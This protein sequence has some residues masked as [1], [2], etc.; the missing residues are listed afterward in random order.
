MK[1]QLSLLIMYL[2]LLVI[3]LS[4]YAQVS[5][6]KGIKWTTGLT[7]EQVKQKAKSENKYVFLDCYTTWCGPCRMMDMQVYSNDSVGDYYNDRFIS[8]KVQMDKTN[9][10]DEEVKKWYATAEAMITD[11]KIEGYPSFVFISP[12]GVIV[13][14]DIGYK[15]ADSLVAIARLAT[16]PGRV[17]DDGY[18][19]Y[20]RLMEDYNKG[21]KN[22][23][24]YPFMINMAMRLNDQQMAVKLLKELTDSVSL[25]PPKERYKKEIIQLWALFTL[26]TDRP[27][28]SFFYNDGKLIDE[29][30]DQKGFSASMVDKSIQ[31]TIVTP[32]LQE[33]AKGSGVV[34]SGMYMSGPELKLDS[35]EADW[36]QLEKM[37]SEK[38]N[39]DVTKRNLLSARV[40]WYKRH[41][42]YPA[43]IKYALDKLNNYPPDLKSPVPVININNDAFT[44]FIYSTDQKLLL[45]YIKWMGKMVKAY[46]DRYTS[47]DTYANLL[48]KAGKRKEAIKWQEKAVKMAPGDPGIAKA[49]EDMRAGKP[50]YLDQ[51]VVW[52]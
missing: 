20:D 17:Y 25:L 37:M 2:S 48:Y 6:S 16:T 22:H 4:T 11:F 28:F 45:G 49:L 38:F 31:G 30:M 19:E 1:K 47:L 41:Q 15:P 8:V 7:W 5:E 46:P 18:A 26:R 9:K 24:K 10:D 40:E 39:A 52:K 42:N 14:K 44:A 35:T 51:G 29:V 27:V 50:T 34:M 13:H 12:E 21:N 23:D 32:F 3:G 43:A 33:Q 36:K